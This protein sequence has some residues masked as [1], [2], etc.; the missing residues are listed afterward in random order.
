[1]GGVQHRMRGLGLSWLQWAWTALRGSGLALA[2]L[3]TSEGWLLTCGLGLCLL[4]QA[5]S[6][7]L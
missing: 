6:L 1:M 5:S 7:C 4:V 2:G 3:F